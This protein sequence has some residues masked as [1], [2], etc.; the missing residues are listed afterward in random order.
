MAGIEETRRSASVGAVR[1]A[2]EGE[3]RAED[4]G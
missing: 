1:A 2:E 3:I 4:G